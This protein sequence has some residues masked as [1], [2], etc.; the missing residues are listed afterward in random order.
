M[1]RI[2]LFLSLRQ[3]KRLKA[4]SLSEGLGFAELIRRAIDSFLASYDCMALP[5]NKGIAH[6]DLVSHAKR[7]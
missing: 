4:L 1:K 6:N 7:K 2:S 5:D 3:I